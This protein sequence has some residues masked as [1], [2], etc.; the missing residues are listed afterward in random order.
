M[1]VVVF[2]G[3]HAPFVCG[4]RETDKLWCAHFYCKDHIHSGI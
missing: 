3:L 4:Q 1:C 2:S